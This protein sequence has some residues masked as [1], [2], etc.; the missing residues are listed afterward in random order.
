MTHT[1]VKQVGIY[2][3]NEDWS[4]EMKQT[5]RHFKTEVTRPMVH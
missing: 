2:T 1:L 4:L 3:E 5:L